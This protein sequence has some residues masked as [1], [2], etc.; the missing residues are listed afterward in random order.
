MTAFDILFNPLRSTLPFED[1]SPREISKFQACFLMFGKS[2]G[3]YRTHVS[4]NPNSLLCIAA[5]QKHDRN[6]GLLS[7]LEADALLQRVEEAEQSG[8]ATGRRI[9]SDLA[10]V[11][12]RHSV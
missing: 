10:A 9:D 7:L 4:T 1:W 6:P 12:L 2:F 5:S 11:L 8:K 3:E